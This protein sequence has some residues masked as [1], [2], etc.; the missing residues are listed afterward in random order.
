MFVSLVRGEFHKT[1]G[2]FSKRLAQLGNTPPLAAVDLGHIQVQ[3]HQ[4]WKLNFKALNCHKAVNLYGL[5]VLMTLI[6]HICM[7]VKIFENEDGK[8]R[9]RDGRNSYQFI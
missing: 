1:L 3:T 8:E 6:V 2:D 9:F 5:K 4:M 7:S